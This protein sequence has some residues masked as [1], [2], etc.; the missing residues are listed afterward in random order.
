MKALNIF[1]GI[2]LASAAH[3]EVSMPVYE[4]YYGNGTY[5]SEIISS[6]Y[7]EA[8]RLIVDFKNYEMNLDIVANSSCPEGQLC[9]M[10]EPEV[11]RIK[12]PVSATISD[13]C[14]NVHVFAQLGKQTVE[15]VDPFSG[16]GIDPEC[17]E[18]PLQDVIV[19]VSNGGFESLELRASSLR[20]I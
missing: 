2:F 16:A 9:T 3:A 10:V 1:F 8:G 19:R 20:E 6:E 15:I 11:R 4:N 14:G 7:V 13:R 18:A 12:L 5:E 17:N